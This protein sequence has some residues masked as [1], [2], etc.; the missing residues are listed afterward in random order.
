MRVR[1]Y[2]IGSACVVRFFFFSSRR[3]HTRLQGDW[4]SDV[5]SSD[6]LRGSEAKEMP[7]RL[8][9]R[10]KEMTRDGSRVWSNLRNIYDQNRARKRMHKE[11]IHC[12]ILFPWWKFPRAYF[13]SSFLV[14]LAVGI[15][16]SVM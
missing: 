6:L 8:F 13:M 15:F 16:S 1:A 7:F 5:C 4:S 11:L 14:S 9:P 3:R 10:V 2:L 12:S